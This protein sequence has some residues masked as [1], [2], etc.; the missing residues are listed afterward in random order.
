MHKRAPNDRTKMVR[1]LLDEMELS[2]KTL[3][4]GDA[5]VFY[6]ILTELGKDV[7]L[8]LDVSEG[9]LGLMSV[10]EHLELGDSAGE[11]LQKKVILANKLNNEYL[12]T[13][14][15]VREDD[16]IAVYQML[17]PEMVKSKVCGL[18]KEALLSFMMDLEDYYQKAN[19]KAD[20]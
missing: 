14:F 10:L 7:G 5:P 20:S 19:S 3:A 15:M 9:R 2:Y 11:E 12:Q 16:F 4:N 6:I 18:I 1:K 17:F 13:K 8:F